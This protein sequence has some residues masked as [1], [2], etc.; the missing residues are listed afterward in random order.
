RAGTEIASS[1]LNGLATTVEGSLTSNGAT[2]LVT[3]R[4]KMMT[5]PKE[6]VQAR[7]FLIASTLIFAVAGLG[8]MAWAVAHHNPRFMLVAGAAL[9]W[10]LYVGWIL[11]KPVAA[12]DPDTAQRA[13]GS[14]SM[15]D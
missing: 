7:K 13:D 9:S 15:R 11:K 8:M 3:E 2:S 12:I 4:R 1:G 6:R 10:T 5:D 14:S